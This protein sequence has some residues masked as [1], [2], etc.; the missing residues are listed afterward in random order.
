MKH[1]KTIIT[2]GS[3]VLTAVLLLSA[4]EAKPKAE[5]TATFVTYNVLADMDHAKTRVPALL[6][7]IGDCDADVIAMQEVAPWFIRELVKTDWF[8][9]YHVTKS[10][11]KII[12]PRGLLI[13]SKQPITSPEFGLLPSRQRRAHLIVETKIRGLKFKI[14]TCHLDSYLKEGAVRA[15]QLDVF[16]KKLKSHENALFLGDFNFG[17]NEQPE[18][19]HIDK[20]YTYLWSKV[21]AGKKGYT[22]NIEKSEMA[23]KGSFPKE[24]SRR[25]DRILI[26][27]KRVKP[28]SANILG[29]KP[30]KGKANIFPSD[31]F[32]LHGKV[33]IE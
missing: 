29:D 33:A 16:F 30:L 19:K 5:K 8:K 20:N 18:T 9:K 11:D 2:V 21:N 10:G 13:L 24:K 4:T 14:A 7:I 25:L 15:V 17:D 26:K 32:G 22:W 12:C 3:V 28:I 6:K 27:S 23:R 1:A 31:H